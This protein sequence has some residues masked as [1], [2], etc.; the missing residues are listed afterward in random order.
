MSVINGALANQTTF[1]NAFLSRTAAVTS[2]VSKLQLANSGSTSV[3]DAQKFLNQAADTAGF[4]EN[5]STRKDYS[6]QNIIA[7]GDSH[8]VAIGKIDQAVQ[9]VQDQVDIVAAANTGDASFTNVGSAP[10]AKGISGV[11]QTFTLQPADAT[12]PGVMTSGTQTIGGNKTF[13]GDISVQGNVEILGTTTTLDTQTVETKDNNLLLNK[14]GSDLSAEGGGLELKRTT[15]N[16]S[17]KFDSALASKWKAGLLGS[18]SEVILAAFTQTLSGDKSFSGFLEVLNRLYLNVA[19]DASPSALALPTTSIVRITAGSGIGSIAPPSKPMMFL[20]T[21]LTGNSG[22][23]ITNSNATSSSIVTGTGSD[24]IVPDGS[25]V[26]FFYDTTS[27]RWRVLSGAGNSGGSGTAPTVATS[28]LTRTAGASLNGFI[29]PTSYDQTILLVSSGGEI[30]LAN[31]LPGA[32]MGGKG[33]GSLLT[34]V[35]TDNDNYC[36]VNFSDTTNGCVG[37]F[38]SIKLTKGVSVTFKRVDYLA[39][40]VYVAGAL[41]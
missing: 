18:E 41:A 30:S 10:N 31:A 4:T 32:S 40:M 6:S 26:L 22:F 11:N 19:N 5:D 7:N 13:T 37:P 20:A 29:D 35:G 14:G 8:K 17:L 39:R 28:V 2:T 12:N 33:D 15:T 36:V 34:L 9:D 23:L 24:I 38:S 27:S 21:N 1:N 25:S 3:D 16:G